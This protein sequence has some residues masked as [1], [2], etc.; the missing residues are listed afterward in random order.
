MIGVEFRTGEQAEAVQQRLFERGLLVLECGESTIRM[1]PPLVVSL[2]Q[3][4]TALRHLR[5]RGGSG[6]GVSGHVFARSPRAEGLP[7]AAR[8]SGAEIFDTDGRRYLDGSGGA[9]VVGIGHGVDSVV[10]CD[11]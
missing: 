6:R 5:R 3:A 10:G 9:I 8:G 2:E 7:V 11:C 1:S 4:N